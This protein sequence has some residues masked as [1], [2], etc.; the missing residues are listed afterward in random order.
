MKLFFAKL[1]L[2]SFTLALCLLL[3]EQALRAIGYEYRPMQVEAGPGDDRLVHLFGSR[4]FIYDPELIWR[5]KPSYEVFNAQGFRGAEL[6]DSKPDG[7]TWIF[8]VGDSNTLGW[9][10]KD[11]AHWPG[12]LRY[13]LRREDPGVEVVNAGVW[14]YASLQGVRRLR[15]VLARGPDLV[16]VS[17]GSNDAHRVPRSDRG[18]AESSNL[19]RELRRRLARYRLAQLFIAAWDRLFA[20]R[21]DELV[22]RVSLADY[23]DNLRRMA[24]DA[25]SAGARL[26]LL[27]RPFEGSITNELWWKNFGPDYNAATV[28]V[29]EELGLPV[30]DLYSHFKDRGEFF[31]DESHFTRTGH[32]LAAE[33]IGERLRP[34]LAGEGEGEAR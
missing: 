20:P 9:S 34:V 6:P 23:R 10:G 16:L 31:H 19:F 21:G 12:F 11:G 13:F 14:G 30:I 26:V 4:H 25:E 27:T 29:A 24:A 3:A 17:F 15:E 28:E 8:A 2:A 1:A 7:A 33:I 32:L 5:P 22:P 18:F